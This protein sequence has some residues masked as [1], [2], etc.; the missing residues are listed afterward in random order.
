[1]WTFPWVLGYPFFEPKTW[2]SHF[3]K[4]LGSVRAHKWGTDQLN[5][6]RHYNPFKSKSA[7]WPILFQAPHYL[8]FWIVAMAAFFW[9]RGSTS[10]CLEWDQ[11]PSVR[12][13]QNSESGLRLMNITP[14]HIKLERSWSHFASQIA[15]KCFD[16]WASTQVTRWPH[17]Q[18]GCGCG[19]WLAFRDI[20]AIHLASKANP[21]KER[22]FARHYFS[23]ILPFYLLGGAL[24]TW[25]SVFDSHTHM[26]N[27][28]SVIAGEARLTGDEGWIFDSLGQI[29]R[30]SVYQLFACRLSM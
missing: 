5:I 22:N 24:P 27:G 6:D 20:V 1:M 25:W 19:V 14:N 21:W 10:S 11:L 16:R 7:K 9:G 26:Q 2:Q 12:L 15:P 13:L 8:H 29:T 23:R 28:A 4:S 17:A 30:G 3:S 18:Q